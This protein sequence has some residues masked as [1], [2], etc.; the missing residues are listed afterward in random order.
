MS[1]WNKDAFNTTKRGGATVILQLTGFCFLPFTI[2]IVSENLQVPLTCET[3]K[4]RNT[5]S[6]LQ[7][8]MFTYGYHGVAYLVCK[9]LVPVCVCLCVHVCVDAG[10]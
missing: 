1:G 5:K 3:I 8:R 2:I 10:L 7:M 9:N 4:K 6:S